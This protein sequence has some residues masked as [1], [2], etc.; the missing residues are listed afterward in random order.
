MGRD[1]GE[2]TTDIRSNTEK[3]RRVISLIGKKSTAERKTAKRATRDR[4]TVGRCSHLSLCIRSCTLAGGDR[5]VLISPPSR[6]PRSLPSPEPTAPSP[7]AEISTR[8][9]HPPPTFSRP[10]KFCPVSRN[11]EEM[12][13]RGARRGKTKHDKSQGKARQGKAKQ[14]KARQDETRQGQVWHAKQGA[15]R[16]KTRQGKARIG[17]NRQDEARQSKTR[18]GKAKRDEARYDA[19][20]C[21]VSRCDAMTRDALRRDETSRDETRCVRCRCVALRCDAMRCDETRC[22][23]DAMRCDAM[24]CDR[25]MHRIAELQHEMKH[26]ENLGFPIPIE[27]TPGKGGTLPLVRKQKS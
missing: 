7:R 3:R 15:T 6:A 8:N 22:G 12:Q 14:G 25:S 9:S 19:M 20:R 24:R 4:D 5:R 16:Q 18:Q 26:I 10:S 2:R 21:D 11:D 23:C 13:G 17:K 1:S 27:G